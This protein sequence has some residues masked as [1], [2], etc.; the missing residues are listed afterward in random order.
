M[1]LAKA[2]QY[3]NRFLG[4]AVWTLFSTH[5]TPAFGWRIATSP[6]TWKRA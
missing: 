1:S 6:N 2:F 5:Q 3:L 4:F